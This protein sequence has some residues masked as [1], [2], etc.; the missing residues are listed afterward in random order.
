TDAS[1]AGTRA[2]PGRAR[3]SR[4]P[5]ASAASARAGSCRRRRALPGRRPR[6]RLGRP[7]PRPARTGPRAPARE[8]P[9]PDSCAHADRVAELDG[10][11]LDV[12]DELLLDRLVEGRRLVA[13]EQL[14]PARGRPGGV[15]ERAVARPAVDVVRR[16]DRR[17]PEAL[18]KALQRV[19]G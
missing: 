2:S 18:A 9:C 17:P 16:R 3:R 19:L 4:A 1:R 13:L 11:A 14:P 10:A 15:V 6:G 8:R 5:R 12:L 7:A